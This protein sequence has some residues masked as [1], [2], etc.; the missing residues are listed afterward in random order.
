[1]SKM[2]DEQADLAER[3]ME[4]ARDELRSALPSSAARYER[5]LERPRMGTS[6][7]RFWP[8]PIYVDHARG[9]RLT[10]IDGREYIDCNMGHGPLVLGHASPVVLKAVEAQLERGTHYGP[11]SPRELELAELLVDGVPGAERVAFLNSGG[12]STMAAVR[13]A[14]EAT[15]R[16]KVAKFEGGLHGNYEPLLFSV[17]AIGGDESDPVPQVDSGGLPP[18]IAETVVMLPFNDERAI[19]R[20]RR[21]GSDW[22][23]VIVEPVQGS[24]GCLPAS[25]EFLKGVRKACS[26]VGALLILDEVITAFRLGPH[27]AAKRYQISADLTTMGKAIGGGFP[28]GAVAGPAGLID[29]TN[30]PPDGAARDAVFVGGTF[31]G[32]PLTAAAGAAQ[33]TELTQHPEHYDRLGVLGERMRSGLQEAMADA[34]IPGFVTGA[35]SMWGGP[36]FTSTLPTCI[37]DVAASDQVAAR[38]YSTYLIL[39]GILMTSPPHLNFLSTAHTEADVDRVIDA[40]RAVLARLQ[41]GGVI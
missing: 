1:M 22:A 35:G 24:A 40:H 13:I 3:L 37:R 19:E 16:E 15:G 4:A 29:L 6:R 26:E 9:A 27:A 34:G 2:V 7:S 14:R 41:S 38:L 32:N 25:E 10:D 5:V 33:L 23:C 28:V 8:L 21:E 30:T 18:G 17:F 39:E 36:Y 11:P 20:I 12:E 31:S